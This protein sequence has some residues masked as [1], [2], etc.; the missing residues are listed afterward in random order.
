METWA[1]LTRQMI[2]LQDA[3][4]SEALLCLEQL[5]AMSQAYTLE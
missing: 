5:V 2:Y 3:D 4:F 1:H